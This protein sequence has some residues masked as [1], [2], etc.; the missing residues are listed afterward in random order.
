M[1]S[2]FTWR[3]GGDGHPD[4]APG[5]PRVVGFAG[6]CVAAFELW[7]VGSG[8]AVAI[9][10]AGRGSGAASEYLCGRGPV[11]SWRALL[12]RFVSK[13]VLGAQVSPPFAV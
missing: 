1:G 12:S 8:S 2:R 6:D 5:W 9:F 10:V 3:I 4:A 11:A 7:A 13:E